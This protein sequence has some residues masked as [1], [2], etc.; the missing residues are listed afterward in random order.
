M[1]WR[2][3]LRGIVVS[4]PTSVAES[5]SFSTQGGFD[6]QLLRCWMLYWDKLDFPRLRNGFIVSDDLD[7]FLG[8]AGILERTILWPESELKDGDLLTW[9][10]FK[11]HEIRNRKQ[12]GRWSLAL[13]TGALEVPE[14]TY[15]VGPGLEVRLLKALP[16]PDRLVPLEDIL[17]FKERRREELAQLWDAVDQIC[18]QYQDD[19]HRPLAEQAAVRRFAREAC[20]AV[21]LTREAGFPFRL[22]TTCARYVAASAIGA[23]LP[24]AFG[25]SLAEVVGNGVLAS[26][27]MLV[28][29]V[30]GMSL[31]PAFTPFAYLVS[32]DAEVLGPDA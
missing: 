27:G 32:Y 19:P 9:P 21:S 7:E 2:D 20:N 30:G 4:T 14:S 31:A 6:D 18:E 23:S 26:A 29:N 3:L 11:A 12:P 28:G 25:G 1:N 10:Y 15:A 16:V 22:V 17:A 24:L 13:G 5:G 8:N